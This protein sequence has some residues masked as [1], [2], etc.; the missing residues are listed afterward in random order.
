MHKEE[1]K[2]TFFYHIFNNNSDHFQGGGMQYMMNPGMRG[3]VP[4]QYA[5]RT[6]GPG[7]PAGVSNGMQQ[8]PP[9]GPMMRAQVNTVSHS[10]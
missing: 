5:T 7:G 6:P 2:K 4:P 1:G 8:I 3:G 9:S 10:L